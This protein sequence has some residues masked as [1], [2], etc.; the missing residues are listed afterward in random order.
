MEDISAMTVTESAKKL[1]GE[2]FLFNVLK[3]WT[4]AAVT[5][6]TYLPIPACKQT[7]YDRKE[8]YT[9]IAVQDN[10]CS[11]SQIFFDSQEH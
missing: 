11:L 7:S 1:K 10:H 3:K 4:C 9:S 6:R 2:P 8:S 5:I